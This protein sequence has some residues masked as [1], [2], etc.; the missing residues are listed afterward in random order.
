MNDFTRL[1][2]T[3]VNR[4]REAEK[5]REQNYIALIQTIKSELVLIQ[6]DSEYSCVEELD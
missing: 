3:F 1:L 4:D 2:E 5:Q 6:K